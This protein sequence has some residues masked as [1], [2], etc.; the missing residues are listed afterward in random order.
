MDFKDS[1]QD[2]FKGIIALLF[3]PFTCL[4][5]A[6]HCKKERV[7][8]SIHF[9]RIAGIGLIGWLIAALSAFYLKHVS[10]TVALAIATA[11]YLVSTAM[12]ITH[13][14]KKHYEIENKKKAEWDQ[15]FHAADTQ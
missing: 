7:D 9:W 14:T 13:A 2:F 4:L 3:H 5:W 1:T 10:L 6:R 8:G 12:F 11:V 15:K